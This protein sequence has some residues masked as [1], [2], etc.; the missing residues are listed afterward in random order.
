MALYVFLLICGSA[1]AV[2][3]FPLTSQA[4]EEPTPAVAKGLNA[5]RWA[6]EA[7]EHLRDLKTAA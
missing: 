7:D 5:I 1:A 4:S 2:M 6:S 3:Y